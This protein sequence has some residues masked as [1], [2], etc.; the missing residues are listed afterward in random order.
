MS[1]NGGLPRHRSHGDPTKQKLSSGK[2][3]HLFANSFLVLRLYSIP[4]LHPPPNHE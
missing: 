4:K 3:C 2:R 1:E